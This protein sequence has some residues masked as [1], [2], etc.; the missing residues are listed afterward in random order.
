[1]QSAD[2]TTQDLILGL[3][4]EH[5]GWLKGLLRRK[6]GC[7]EQAADLAQ[8]TFVRLI[9]SGRTPQQGESKAHLA[10]IAKGLV[11]DLYRRQS[12]E[13]AYYEA[14]M[15]LPESQTP[16]LETQAIVFETLIRINEA[17]EE[18][19]SNVREAFLLSQFD[20]LTYS[21]IAKQLNIS[22]GAVRKYM[23]KAAQACFLVLSQ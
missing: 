23:L 18:L 3:Y 13:Q 16:S 20:G 15:Q 19:P 7:N 11:I 12:L 9:T 21:E 6:L 17:L 4:N 1:M 22:V 2:P 14:L 8:D 5:H 10:Q